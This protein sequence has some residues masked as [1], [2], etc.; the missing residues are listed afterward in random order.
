MGACD[1]VSLES[2]FDTGC[3]RIFVT[4][5]RLCKHDE[6]SKRSGCRANNEFLSQRVRPLQDAARQRL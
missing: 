4:W 1:D 5:R 3:L 6:Q 2:G